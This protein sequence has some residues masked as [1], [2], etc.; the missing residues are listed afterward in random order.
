MIFGKKGCNEEKDWKIR[1]NFTDD[2]WIT[3][4]EQLTKKE[5]TQKFEEL[6]KALQDKE[7]FIEFEREKGSKEIIMKDN[8]VNISLYQY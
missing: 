2:E 8:I 7:P 1:I 4:V 3:I 6:K 5:A